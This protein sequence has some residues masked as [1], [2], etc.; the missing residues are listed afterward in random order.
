MQS[1]QNTIHIIGIGGSGMLPLAELL[2]KQ[3][4]SVSGSDRLLNQQT[5]ETLSPPIRKRLERLINLG[6]TIVPQD[7]SGITN[8][9]IRVV[10]STAIESSNPDIQAAQRLS[11]PVLHRS[12][13]LKNAVDQDYLLGICGT[14][15]KSTSAALCAWLL[16]ALHDLDVFVGGAEI[17]DQRPDGIGWT[18]VHTGKGR[19]SVLELDESDKS[20]LRFT[21]R[22]ALILNITR[23]HHPLEEN[24]D[25]FKTFTE[26]VSGKLVLNQKDEG[27]RM[28]AQ[29]LSPD[30]VVWFSP[31]EKK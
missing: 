29:Q 7:G 8:N 13:E 3:G 25:I 28:L 21:P 16:M 11:I 1:N 24:I 19:W 14:S 17:L 30:K 26:Q 27:C 22:H 9:T 5:L 4:H 10:I 20:L 12:E 2:L 23:D 18:A 15:G 6:A 31:P